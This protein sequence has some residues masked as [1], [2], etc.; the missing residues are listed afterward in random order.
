MLRIQYDP[1]DAAIL[2][3]YPTCRLL[4]DKDPTHPHAAVEKAKIV[5]YKGVSPVL[6]S[7]AAA[8]RAVI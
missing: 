6:S 3:R 7:I 1:V 4:R 8:N 2:D 5:R